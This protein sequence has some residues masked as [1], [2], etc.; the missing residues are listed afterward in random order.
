MKRRLEKVLP[1]GA[2]DDPG[3]WVRRK[4]AGRPCDEQPARQAP[5]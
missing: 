5:K 4:F 1:V 2:L 3:T